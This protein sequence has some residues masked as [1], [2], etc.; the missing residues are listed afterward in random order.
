MMIP[1]WCQKALPR[2]FYF[3]HAICKIPCFLHIAVGFYLNHAY[4]TVNR[5]PMEHCSQRFLQFP[6]KGDESYVPEDYRAHRPW[7]QEHEDRA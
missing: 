7:E 1:E 2:F 6:D 3:M 4:K 5:E